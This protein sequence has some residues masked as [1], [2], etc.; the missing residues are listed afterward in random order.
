MLIIVQCQFGP[1]ELVTRIQALIPAA[2][3]HVP[4]AQPENAQTRLTG[5]GGERDTNFAELCGKYVGP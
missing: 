2:L 5:T 3:V 4:P 1:R